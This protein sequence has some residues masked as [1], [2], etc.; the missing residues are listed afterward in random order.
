[1]SSLPRILFY[2]ERSLHL[3]Y[4]EPIQEYLEANNLALTAYSAPPYCEGSQEIPGCGLMDFEGRRLSA[5]APFF[6]EPWKFEPD[7]TIVA[8]ACH[9]RIP[10]IQNVI[11]VGHGLISKGA[12]YTDSPIV[13]RENLSQMILVPGPW[14]RSRIRDNVFIPI[15]VTG[16]I[17]SDLL[18]GPGAQDRV[19][20]CR[21][22]GIDPGKRIVLFAPTYNRELSAIPCV[23]QGISNVADDKTIL[24]IKLHNLTET[25]WK[26]L[27]KSIARSSENILYMEDVDYSGIMHA[28]DVMISDVSSMFIEFLLLDKPVVLFNNPRID[29]FPLYKPQDIEYQTRDAGVQVDSLEG[30]LKAVS[31]EL[32]HPKQRSELRQRY[33][34]ALDYG[35]DGKSAAR[36]GQA[37]LEWVQGKI[38][39]KHPDLEV[40]LLEPAE[41]DKAGIRADISEIVTKADGHQLRVTVIGGREDAE[42]MRVDHVLTGDINART[43]C[44]HLRSAAT[45]FVAIVTGG[46]VMPWDWPKWLE[47]HFRWNQ[48]VGAVKALTEPG[49]AAQCMD[50]LKAANKNAT[51][52]TESMSQGL[53]LAGIGQ[54][55]EGGE[56][57]SECIMV[58]DTLLRN[59]PEGFPVSTPRECII[60]LGLLPLK[61]GMRTLMAVDCSMQ[62]VGRF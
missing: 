57:P 9:H 3:P 15:K 54:S 38:R 44:D 4:L 22:H 26:K 21:Q 14:H 42:D 1:M 24:L 37:I 50:Q 10:D 19:S 55:M 17:K 7:V 27:Y 62:P 28:A 34:R 51:I 60:A 33:A 40:F 25:R 35:R 8:D 6:T 53:L 5:K 47:N 32:A 20:F 36:A 30:L 12:F 56:L 43:L 45:P 59:I 48:G 31:E 58:C 2:V 16:F 29:E 52:A 39:Q 23:A 11:N 61:Q 13:R 41:A 46:L 18:F 49:L